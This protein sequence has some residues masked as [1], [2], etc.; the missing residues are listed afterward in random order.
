MTTRPARAS[1]MGALVLSPEQQQKLLGSGSPNEIGRSDVLGHEMPT[2]VQRPGNLRALFDESILATGDQPFLVS[3]ANTW[4][5]AETR[6]RIDSVAAVMAEDYGVSAGDRIAI[7]SA[8][9]PAY[10]VAMWATVSLGAIVTGLNGWWTGPEM[11]Y[12]IELTQP[13]LLLG[14]GPRLNRLRDVS[15]PPDLPVVEL[16]PLLERAKPNDGSFRPAIVDEDE[17][18]IILFTSGTT[19][20]P[21]GAVLSHRNIITLASTGRLSRSVGAALV[22]VPPATT[23][24]PASI[25]SSPMFHVSGMAAVF[26]TGPVFGTKMVFPPPGRWDPATHLQ[27]T[28]EHAVSSWS[29]VPTQYWRIFRHPDFDP[30]SLKSLRSAGSGGAPYAPEL[31]QTFRKLLPWVTLTNGYGMTESV[32]LGTLNAGPAMIARPDS[33]GTAQPGLEIEIRDDDGEV[34]AE[35]EVGQ[36][37]LRGTSIFLGYWRDDSASAAALD[38]DRW[39]RTGDFG[40]IADGF[41]YL[42]SRMRDLIIRGGENIYPIEVENRLMAH[43]AIHDAAVIGTDHLELGQEVKAFVV[44]QPGA[45][46]SDSDVR[47]WVRVGLASFKVPTQVTFAD[48]LPYT[49]SGK[50]IKAD[51]ERQSRESTTN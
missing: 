27:L 29:G 51:L 5:F 39:Y 49:E 14:D 46:L 28:V 10:A 30:E 22:P 2:F 16:D 20:R 6:D 50:V 33:V 43:P 34:V 4:T 17:P 19:G 48:A 1:W 24:Q 26:M 35:G 32:G 15:L 47:E 42:E 36:I 12:G 7:A 37:H 41:L 23:R 18:A 44:L 21:K 40:R 38:P 8:N 31:V 45:A 13:R 11:S 25:L 3:G 9:S